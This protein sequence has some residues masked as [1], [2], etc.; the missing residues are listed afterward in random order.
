MNVK[1]LLKHKDKFIAVVIIIIFG[2]II[3]NT[4]VKF[5][6]KSKAI[7]E[8]M[9]LLSE[10]KK[11][12]DEWNKADEEYKNKIKNFPFKDIT[13]FKRFVEQKTK[14]ENIYISSMRPSQEDKNFYRE[15]KIV[16]DFTSSYKN[17][18]N[19]VKALE[20]N[21]A[22]IEKLVVEN[23]PPDIAGHMEIVYNIF[24]E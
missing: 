9:N 15:S 18:V 22:T 14:E 1:D 11:I 6:A 17:I 10:N 13:T 8:Q 23:I 20:E 3:K 2:V 16:L 7:A 5:D 21:N 4:W 24:K 12:I 19:F